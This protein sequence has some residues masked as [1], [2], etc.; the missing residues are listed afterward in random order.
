MTLNFDFNV[1]MY[2][3]P[4]VGFEN[5]MYLV[6]IAHERLKLYKLFENNESFTDE[7]LKTRMENSFLIELLD[8]NVNVRICEARRMDY[9]SHWVLRVA[10]SNNNELFFIKNELMWFQIRFNRMGS[11]EKRRFMEKHNFI[12]PAVSD[13]VKASLKLDRHVWYKF[14]FT[15]VPELL[16]KRIYPL[17]GGYIYIPA[18]KIVYWLLNK[19]ENSL[20]ESLIHIK[21]MIISNC[22]D[23]LKTILS[24]LNLVNPHGYRSIGNH[25]ELD[26]LDERS[27]YFPLCMKF[28][29]ETLRKTHHLKYFSRMQYGLF[30]KGLGLSLEDA[31]ELWRGEFVKTMPEKQFWKKYSYL[32]KHQYGTVGS[33]IDYAPY[34][35]AKIL[36]STVTTNQIHGCPFKHWDEDVLVKRLKSDGISNLKIA[37]IVALVRRKKYTQACTRYLQCHHKNVTH[38]II[39]YPNEYYEKLCESCVVD[40]EDLFKSDEDS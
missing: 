40:I 10:Y 35:C 26:D 15:E 3:D 9:L 23:Q 20:K 25:I 27:K 2:Q 38:S 16:K 18:H 34:A 7:E 21:K 11:D 32:F 4:P 17:C 36:K 30:L 8:D 1:N 19:L 28:Q 29:H 39:T 31:L 6:E 37:E 33:R 22:D 14:K 12:F 13:D 24:M 5:V